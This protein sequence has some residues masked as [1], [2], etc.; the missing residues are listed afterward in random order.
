MVKQS[1]K[2]GWVPPLVAY[3]YKLYLPKCLQKMFQQDTLEQ[4]KK[5]SLQ[6]CALKTVEHTVDGRNPAPVDR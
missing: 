6:R 2:V 5:L 3:N 1:L 4:Q